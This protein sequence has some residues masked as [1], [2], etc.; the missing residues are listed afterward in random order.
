VA[1]PDEA[2]ANNLYRIAQEAV[3]NATKYASATSIHVHLCSD[4]DG[5]ITLQVADDGIGLPRD[6]ERGTGMGLRIMRYR[7]HMIGGTLSIE[8]GADGTGTVVRC[9]IPAAANRPPATAAAAATTHASHAIA[10]TGANAGAEVD[11]GA[12]RSSSRPRESED[13]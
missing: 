12:A 11:A 5:G 2:V 1:V 4:A 10:A 13:A 6:A 3:N 8:R 9:E 7:A